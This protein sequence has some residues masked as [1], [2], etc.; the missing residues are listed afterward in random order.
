MTTD[1]LEAAPT[2][3]EW[4]RA[5]DLSIV[6]L[7]MEKVAATC[8]E[9]ARSGGREALQYYDV[10]SHQHTLLWMA[11]MLTRGE[12]CGLAESD[13]ELVRDVGE[14][15]LAIGGTVDSESDPPWVLFNPPP[16]PSRSQ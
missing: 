15:T 7:I 4:Y 11:Y 12:Q 2:R 6:A 14:I 8:R 13:E 1:T 16:P 9:I 5:I 10:C 3:N